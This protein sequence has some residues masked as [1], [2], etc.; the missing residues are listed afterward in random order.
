MG[1][2]GVTTRLPALLAM[3][4]LSG[5]AAQVTGFVNDKTASATVSTAEATVDEAGNCPSGLVIDP[6]K[7]R[8]REGDGLMG[9]TECELVALK[10]PPTSVQVGASSAHKRETMLLYFDPATGKTIYLFADNRLVR[11]VKGGDQGSG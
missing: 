11:I 10:G 8:G 7:F 9:A 2:E 5:C 3:L 6:S 4:V 1:E